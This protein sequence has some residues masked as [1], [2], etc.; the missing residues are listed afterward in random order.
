M[1]TKANCHWVASSRYCS[2]T[3]D[4]QRK[5]TSMLQ[6]SYQDPQVLNVQLEITVWVEG[7][8]QHFHITKAVN[9]IFK[10]LCHSDQQICGNENFL[11]GDSAQIDLCFHIPIILCVYFQKT[12]IYLDRSS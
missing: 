2:T 1:G 6:D 7:P 12:M 11:N 9:W 3:S 4:R 8:I 5:I 10:D